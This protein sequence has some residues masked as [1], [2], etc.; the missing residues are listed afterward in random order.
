MSAL[1][2]VAL[3][4][5]SVIAGTEGTASCRSCRTLRSLLAAKGITASAPGG[6]SRNLQILL[7]PAMRSNYLEMQ[8]LHALGL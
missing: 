5:Q 6:V 3:V 8:R 4:G 1:M 2:D 7:E